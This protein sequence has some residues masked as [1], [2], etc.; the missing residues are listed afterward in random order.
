MDEIDQVV[1]EAKDVLA[2]VLNG[3]IPDKWSVHCETINDEELRNNRLP[4]VSDL[5]SK[6]LWSLFMV[7]SWKGD[8]RYSANECGKYAYNCLE[9]IANDMLEYLEPNDATRLCREWL[10]L[11]EGEK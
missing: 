6:L 4:L 5:A 7:S 9:A 8:Y 1:L 3:P 10:E 2:L 11:M